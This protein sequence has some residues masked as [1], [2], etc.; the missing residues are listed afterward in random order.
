METLH[1]RFKILYFLMQE[2]GFLGGEKE[3]Q[4][5]ELANRIDDQDP[6]AEEALTFYE[7]QVIKAHEVDDQGET[8]ED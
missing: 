4:I 1:R 8:F 7:D 2:A 5:E 6:Q 3:Q